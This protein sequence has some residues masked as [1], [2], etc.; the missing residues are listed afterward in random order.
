MQIVTDMHHKEN[1]TM[2]PFI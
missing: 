2:G 1:L